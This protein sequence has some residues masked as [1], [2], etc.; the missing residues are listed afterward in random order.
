MKGCWPSGGCDLH[1]LDASELE[2]C[3]GL[4]LSRGGVAAAEAPACIAVV[5]QAQVAA[6]LTQD[7]CL[8]R[9]GP[10]SSARAPRVPGP[11]LFQ[12]PRSAD[13]HTVTTA[14]PFRCP[15]Q[16]ISG[17]LEKWP[18][19][20][21]RCSMLRLDKAEASDDLIC[22]QLPEYLQDLDD[23]ATQLTLF[24]VRSS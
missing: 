12:E 1:G 4:D 7:L 5:V 16:A 11:P 14:A 17:I 21:Q 20:Q 10:Q 24:Q 8:D 18:E 13:P 3:R 23:F 2:C 19:E 15:L 9:R 6:A 22:V